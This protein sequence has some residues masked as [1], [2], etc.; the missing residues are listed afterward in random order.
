MSHK[1]FE[2][3]HKSKR[4][5]YIRITTHAL[6]LA[7]MALATWLG[8]RREKKRQAKIDAINEARDKAHR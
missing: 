5:L 1:D 3:Y 8:N 4:A 6:G 7:G 2:R